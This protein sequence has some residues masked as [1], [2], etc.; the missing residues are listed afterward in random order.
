MH[1]N[2]SACANCDTARCVQ[3]SWRFQ[4]PT[5]VWPNIMNWLTLSVLGAVAAWFEY[6]YQRSRRKRMSI[7]ASQEPIAAPT[8]QPA[9]VAQLDEAPSIAPGSENDKKLNSAV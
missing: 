3:R 5:E 7:A 8:A 9:R 1:R 4:H 6:S 2:T